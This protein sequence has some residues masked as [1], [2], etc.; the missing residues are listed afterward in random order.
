[1]YVDAKE[2]SN[3][4]LSAVFTNSKRKVWD[5]QAKSAVILLKTIY[6]GFF[7]ARGCVIVT[8]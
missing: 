6:L 2:C 7:S 8:A 1:M 5:P 3:H 4:S